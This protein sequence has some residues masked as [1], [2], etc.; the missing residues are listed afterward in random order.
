M[1]D[2]IKQR[3]REKAEE[4]VARDRVLAQIKQ[5]QEDRK[6][7]FGQ[8][9]VKAVKPLVISTPTQLNSDQTRI[10]FRLPD[11]STMKNVFQISDSLRTVMKYIEDNTPYRSFKLATNFP[12]NE[13]GENDLDKTLVDLKLA[14]SAVLIVKKQSEFQHNAQFNN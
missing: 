3:E 9:E 12:K 1:E 7:R 10:Q 8:G 5:D 6:A 14:P 4:K 2:A 13:Y 11:S